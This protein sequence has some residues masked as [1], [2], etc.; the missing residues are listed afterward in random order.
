MLHDFLVIVFG[1]LADVCI[2]DD[3]EIGCL[4]GVEVYVKGL[5]EFVMGMGGCLWL[6][7]GD[8]EFEGSGEVSTG[9]VV[10]EVD[11]YL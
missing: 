6:E 9:V 4:L 1:W 7:L 10:E 8:V 3:G 5:G 11:G 2:D